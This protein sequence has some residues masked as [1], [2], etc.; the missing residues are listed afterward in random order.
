MP[1]IF[2][3]AIYFTEFVFFMTF[4]IYFIAKSIFYSLAQF[5]SKYNLKAE[6]SD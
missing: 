2:R 1:Q 3:F 4:S 5:E 6:N